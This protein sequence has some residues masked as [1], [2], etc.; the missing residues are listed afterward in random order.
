[1]TDSAETSITASGSGVRNLQIFT[2]YNTVILR[3]TDHMAVGWDPP[4]SSFLPIIDYQ[5]D[6]LREVAHYTVISLLGVTLNIPARDI[7]SSFRLSSLDSG[8]SNNPDSPGI[9]D[10]SIGFNFNAGSADFLGI[11]INI[12][13][14][15]RYTVTIRPVYSNNTLGPAETAFTDDL[16][17]DVDPF[18][19]TLG[20]GLGF[21]NNNAEVNLTITV[22]GSTQIDDL[23]DSVVF[24]FERRLAGG[25]W[26]TVSH[27]SGTTNDNK[28]VRFDG[29]ADYR[30]SL[31]L[32]STELGTSNELRVNAP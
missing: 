26:E 5:I 32:A 29:T 2:N 13:T 18:E 7:E 28:W 23:F 11:V 16:A 6:S 31:A 10:L 4:E 3:Y 15:L 21:R 30:V 25:S 1:M 22:S 27:S 8:E 14:T 20:P 24:S 19:I 17:P 12:F 9:G